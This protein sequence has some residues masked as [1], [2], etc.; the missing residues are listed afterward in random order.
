M[1]SYI[2][3]FLLLTIL[4]IPVASFSETDAPGHHESRGEKIAHWLEEK[5]LSRTAAV[6]AISTLPIVELRGAVPVGIVAF[7][8]PWWKVYLIAVA[9]KSA[10]DR[11]P[12]VLSFQPSMVS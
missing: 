7:D 11:A 10:Q 3:L 12:K 6:A 4:L 5:G 1:K 2:P 9:G 8:M